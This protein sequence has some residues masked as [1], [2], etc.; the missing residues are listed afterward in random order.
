[1]KNLTKIL[2]LCMATFLSVVNISCETKF[3]DSKDIQEKI[4]KLDKAGWEAWK[5]KS[6]EW[7]EQN[8]TSNFVSISADGVSDKKEVIAATISNCNVTSY[9]LENIK[10]SMLSD[11][12]ALLT[13]KVF[14]DGTCNGVK[15]SPK[16]QVA[17]NYIFQNDKWLEAFYMESKME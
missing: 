13:Y 17:A 14:Q 15:L 8:T 3:D 16:I 1:M 9:A 11:K 10:F 6:G 7:F 5:N 12:S 4:I 2:L